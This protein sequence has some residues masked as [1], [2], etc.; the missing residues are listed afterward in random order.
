MFRKW[1][2]WAPLPL[3]LVMGVS[4]TAA[5]F[6]KVFTTA[7]HQNFITEMS[8]WHIP[9][10][11]GN[12][13]TWLIGSLEFASGLLVLIGLWVSLV[14]V[15]QT[16]GTIGLVIGILILGLPPGTP[17]LDYFPYA[18]PDVPYSMAIVAGLLTLLFGGAGK[19][20]IDEL[21]KSGS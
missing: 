7:G 20:S 2:E 6:L 9:Y 1:N 10:G 11:L 16:V 18:L 19:F 12:A 13:L 15:V 3:R 14:A 8:H 5:G 17:G 21:R 4:Y